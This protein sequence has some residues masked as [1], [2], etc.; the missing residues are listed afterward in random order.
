LREFYYY[1]SSLE[2]QGVGEE[3]LEKKRRV[4][5]DMSILTVLRNT[6]QLVFAMPMYGVYLNPDEGRELPR[7]LPLTAF[8]RQAP[9]E[10]L[11]L[12]PGEE[13]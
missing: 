13:I 3:R 2:K 9:E 12:L 5:E 10:P 8:D 11:V 1:R 4:L 6:Q 7:E